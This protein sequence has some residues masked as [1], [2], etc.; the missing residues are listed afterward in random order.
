MPSVIRVCRKCGT[1]IF[2]DAPEGLCTGCVLETALGTFPD[3]V[4]GVSDPGAS[5]NVTRNDVAPTSANKVPAR[6][7]KLLGEL[8]D[9]ELLEEV[10][11]GGQGVVFRARQ[12]SLNRIVAL[13][14]IGL[15]QWATKAH[16]KRFRLEAEAAASL[17]HPC[18][19]PIYEVGERDGQCYFSMKFVE[20]GQLDEVV[21]R[22]PMPIRQATE[23]IAKVARTVYYAHEHGILHRDIKPGNI[24]LDAKGEPQ[25]TDFGLARLVESESTITRTLEVLGTPSYMAPEQARGSPIQGAAVSSPPKNARLKRAVDVYGLGAVLYQLLTGHPPFAGGTTYETIKLLLETEPRPPRLWNSKVDRDLSTICLKCL[26]KDP[27]RRYSSALV[28]AED[29][30]RWLTYQ[31]IQAR[32][33]AVVGRGKKWLQRNPTAAGIAVLSLALVAAVG[34]IVW[35]SDPFRRPPGAGIA[36]LPF[37]NLSNDREDASFADGV[38]DDLLTKLAKIADLKVISRT[39]VM[40]YRGK[41]NAHRIGDELGVSHLL[42]GSVRKTGSWL[43]INA[44]LIDARKDAHIWAEDYD[45]DLKDIFAIQS[46]IAQ[47]VAEQL[48]V[49]ISSAERL[50]IERPP[51]ADI[52]AFDLYSRAKNLVLAWNSSSPEKGNLLQAAN[53]LNQSV[54]RDPSFFQGYCQLAWVND[55]LYFFRFDRTP[56]RLALAKAAIETAF[57]LRPDAGEAHLAR[58][59]NLYHGYLDYDGALAELEIARKTLP[60]DPRLFELKGYIERRRPGGNQEK[61]LRELERAID[62]D[63]RNSIL[64]RNIALSYKSLR[65]YW[66]EQAILDRELAIRPDDVYLKG[67]R[68]FVDLDW[69]ANPRP[70]HALIDSIRATNPVTM[71]EIADKWLTCA[72]AERD[73]AAAVNALA[74]RGEKSLGNE[75]VKYSPLFMEGLIAQMTQDNAKAR[76]AFT[77]AR[78]EQEKLVRA[79]PDDAGALSVLGLIDAALGRKEEALRE[80]RRAVEL[81]PVEKDVLNGVRMIAGLARIAA[82]V[83]D[84]DLACE[85]LTHASRLPSGAVSY[86]QL[87]LLPWWD[88]LRGDPCFEKIVASL[89]PK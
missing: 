71:P 78:A 38:Q 54:T 64:L 8:G 49:K 11:R 70:L 40:G 2:S 48:R 87:K 18:I 17:D 51:T 28:L 5:D 7:V 84:K 24:L 22:S 32:R 61:A 39:S 62:L 85:Q 52:T 83:G 56:E 37:E 26:E 14:V 69:K 1:T 29:L 41:Q 77:A 80:G 47:R 21:R 73:A 88:P 9:Y 13:K 60:N 12:K 15:G 53:L 45:R 16:L 65:R 46:D 31:P 20:G 35:K 27:Q 72:F 34:V 10:G 86:G 75:L 81:L 57:R 43:H 33:T 55:R 4:A 76:A 59:E 23:L 19:V 68:A 30:D 63:P 74:A 82:S 79:D 6:A 58:A 44:Q 89:A 66:E 3:A 36:V 42:E 50:A 25:L 67:A